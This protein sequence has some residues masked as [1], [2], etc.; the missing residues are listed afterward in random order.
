MNNRL[1][2]V[3]PILAVLLCAL[4]STAG[5]V[6]EIRIGLLVD[7]PNT[8]ASRAELRELVLDEVVELM[9]GEFAVSFPADKIL[10]ADDTAPGIERALDQLLRDPR[11]DLVL[12]GG[13][14]SSH[15]ASRRPSLS[16]PVIAPLI[17]DPK[18]QGI[19][20]AGQSSGVRNL[21]YITYP[22]SIPS[23]LGFFREIAPLDKVALL[24]SHSILNSIPHV[25]SHFIAA[26]RSIGVEVVPVPA[27]GT[28]AS[29][30]GALPA[31]VDGV[32]I[33]LPLN[34]ADDEVEILVQ[35]LIDRRMPPG[36]RCRRGSYTGSP[37]WPHNPWRLPDRCRAS[38]RRLAA[39]T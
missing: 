2:E 9:E 14:I 13:P 11:V 25:Q 26:G 22:A 3:T 28:A 37:L 30:L 23:T 24:A 20:L 36:R 32:F 15:L 29:V 38:G 8:P 7:G 10:V 21:S 17:M 6:S 5:A 39:E 1:T 16:K 12:C 27:A 35:G 34:L 33:G 19:P 4:I 31:D 18:L